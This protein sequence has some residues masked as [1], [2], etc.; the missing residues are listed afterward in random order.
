MARIIL[1]ILVLL[2]FPLSV[3]ADVQPVSLSTLVTIQNVPFEECT[4]IFPIE[5]ENLFY[6]T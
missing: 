1:L 2:I 6:L 5:A 3:K 4:R